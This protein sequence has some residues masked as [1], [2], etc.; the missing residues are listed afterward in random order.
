MHTPWLLLQWAVRSS[1]PAR[2]ESRGRR[3]DAR[4]TLASVLSAM[5][6][7]CSPAARARFFTRIYMYVYMHMY[8]ET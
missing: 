3:R 2:L 5:H 4:D 6:G 1:G 8:I 7:C